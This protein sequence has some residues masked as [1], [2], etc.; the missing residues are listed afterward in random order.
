VVKDALLKIGCMP[1]E[2]DDFPPDYRTVADFLQSEIA[3]CN[4]VIHIAGK[5]YGAEP[6][7]ATLPP[8]TVRRSYTQLEYDAGCKLNKKVYTFICADDFPYDRCEP[9]GELQTLLQ[10]AHRQ[11]LAAGALKYDPVNSP[12]DINDKVRQLRL[13]L[14][15]LAEQLRV[16]NKR[17]LVAW[18][19]VGVALCAV[20]AISF[21][22]WGKLN[23]ANEGVTSLDAKVVSLVESD[24]LT[25]ISEKAGLEPQEIKQLVLQSNSAGVGPLQYA[26]RLME[27]KRYEAAY[28]L[29]RFVGETA[30]LLENSDYRVAAEAFLVAVT[31]SS[32]ISPESQKREAAYQRC[33]GNAALAQ[34][35]LDAIRTLGQDQ[36]Q[37]ASDLYCDLC[38][39]QTNNLYVAS[40]NGEL[41]DA[42]EMIAKAID[43]TDEALER[44][45]ASTQK[46]AK[47]R[48]RRG[49]LLG[50]KA[51]WV[52]YREAQELLE[53]G[54][55]ECNSALKLLESYPDDEQAG[56]THNAQMVIWIELA[57]LAPERDAKNLLM[58][59]RDAYRG[60]K[61]LFSRTKKIDIAAE[62]RLFDGL[63][64]L[65]L[66]KLA[67]SH[68][69]WEKLLAEATQILTEVLKVAEKNELQFVGRKAAMGL[70]VAGSLDHTGDPESAIFQSAMSYGCHTPDD[71]L[72]YCEFARYWARHGLR[73]Q[74]YVISQAKKTA[75]D[76]QSKY[77]FAVSPRRFADLTL[78][79]AECEMAMSKVNRW[80]K[81]GEKEWGTSSDN[82][83]DA[84]SALRLV[85]SKVSRE[86]GS[87]A[88]ANARRY[89][90]AWMTVDDVEGSIKA[91]QDALT[92]Y[93]AESDPSIHCDVCDNL[94]EAFTN[95]AESE[96]D[97][98]AKDSAILSALQHSVAAAKVWEQA[99]ANSTWA[100]SY[101]R[102]LTVRIA[103][104]KKD[105]PKEEAEKIDAA[106]NK[107]R[108]SIAAKLK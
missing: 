108:E 36:Q 31:A 87:R 103:E 43:E 101:E 96:P 82:V 50:E 59:V 14:E 19:A 17:Q 28:G 39:S 95:L 33:I 60:S 29:A 91:S 18:S 27:E 54:L 104:L 3:K 15:E 76:G 90:G 100:D 48:R 34:R 83:A 7:P 41:A 66:C 98:A 84:H 105:R 13:Q 62:N 11:S 85:V 64:A 26:N 74:I 38:L 93:T 69:E 97:T 42:R 10:N 4:A 37:D 30:L 55:R 21:I 58:H 25:S 106:V 45:G 77:S 49:F 6:D 24:L 40:L 94:S 71:V 80:T 72:A 51:N 81:E 78:A 86:D 12:A 32:S 16:E 63:A 73:G 61:E 35:G 46:V 47:L 1:V 2:Q 57:K 67:T 53:E 102:R 9:E 65:E 68:E 56:I 99:Y 88:W 92:V 107:L 75:Y 44:V 89:Y 8:G 70:L 52:G 22:V 20:L 79:I 23:R 5:R